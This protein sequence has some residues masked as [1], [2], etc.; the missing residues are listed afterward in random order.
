V[1]VADEDL[2]PIFTKTKLGTLVYV[3]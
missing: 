2:E 1:R 3:F